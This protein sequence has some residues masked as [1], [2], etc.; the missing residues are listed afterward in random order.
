LPPDPIFGAMVGA[1]HVDDAIVNII[2][3]WDRTYLQ[4]VARRSDEDVDEL[5]PFRGWR[6]SWELEK[7]PEDQTPTCIVANRGINEPPKK[8]NSRTRPGQTY[9]ATWNYRVGV[10]TSARGRKYNAMPRAERLA[11]MYTLAIRTILV[12]KRDQY[13]DPNQDKILGMIDWVDEGYDGL[14]SDADRSICLAWAEFLVTATETATWGTGPTDPVIDVDPG[15]PDIGMWPLVTQVIP[16][17]IKV[18][19][20]Q[21]INEFIEGGG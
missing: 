17:I 4:E 18:P 13:E 12:Q 7:M 21:A 11:K 1:H 2:K 19:T 8:Y 15:D 14:D 20:E 9:Q 5:L 16:E 3:N 10:L 6:V